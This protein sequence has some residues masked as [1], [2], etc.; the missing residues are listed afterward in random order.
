MKDQNIFYKVTISLI[1]ITISLYN[2]WVL[3]GEID[4]GHY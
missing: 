4:A 3:L 2:V 1:H